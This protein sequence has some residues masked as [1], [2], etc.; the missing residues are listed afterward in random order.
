MAAAPTQVQILDNDW[1]TV[2]ETVATADMT[3]HPT[4]RQ[5]WEP[6]RRIE[7]HDDVAALEPG[8]RVAVTGTFGFPAVPGDV[9]QAVLDE[10]ANVMDRDV[11][12]YSQDLA[13]NTGGETATNVIVLGNRPRFL[14]MNPRSLAVLW[15]Y[16]DLY[17]G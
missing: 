12:H 15:S 7:L 13:P 4:V 11:E 8:M 1:A 9:R 5:T 3:L 2:I 17:I 6:I 10:V 16:R 14:S